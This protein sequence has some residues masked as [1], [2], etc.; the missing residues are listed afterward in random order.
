MNRL[1]YQCDCAYTYVPS[2]LATVPSR[3]EGFEDVRDERWLIAEVLEL[4]GRLAD[5]HDLHGR[6][7]VVQGLGLVPV[8]E[9]LKAVGLQERGQS[10]H[11]GRLLPQLVCYTRQLR[12]HGFVED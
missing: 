2:T 9:R 3:L 1:R 11:D 8:Q 4:F 12:C 10:V 6:R 5:C 7:R